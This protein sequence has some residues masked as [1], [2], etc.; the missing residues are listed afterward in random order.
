V[1]TP[2]CAPLV[3]ATRLREGRAAAR[4]WSR[5]VRR[6]CAV[7][8]PRRGNPH[9]STPRRRGW[10]ARAAA[11]RRLRP[12]ADRDRSGAP[13]RGRRPPLGPGYLR[14]AG[15]RGGRAGRAGGSCP[16]G[17]AVLGD[18]PVGSDRWWPAGHRRRSRGCWVRPRSARH[19]ARPTSGARDRVQ[20][21]VIAHQTGLVVAGGTT[22]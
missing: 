18:S 16:G 4:P 21:V 15:G 9:G 11:G 3:V 8:R 7:G 14:Q 22:W 19:A 10:G 12:G 20:L 2:T 5:R 1:S 17:N 6:L 13:H